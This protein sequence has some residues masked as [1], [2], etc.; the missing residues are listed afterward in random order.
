[1][2]LAALALYLSTSADAQRTKPVPRIDR[3]T[4][5]TT[6]DPRVDKTGPMEG[7]VIKAIVTELVDTSWTK[8]EKLRALYMWETKH[9]AFDC[10]AYHHPGNYAANASV[11]LNERKTTS[12]GFALFFKAMCDITGIECYVVEGLLRT[13]PG[14]IGKL[15]NKHRHYWNVAVID[16]VQYLVDPT[17]GAGTTDA[18]K[19]KFT[20]NRTDVWWL[21]NRELFALSHYP[22][23]PQWQLLEKPVTRSEFSKA[24]VITAHTLALGLLPGHAASGMLRGR[25]D[26]VVHLHYQVQRPHLVRNVKISIEEG[27]PVPVEYALDGNNMTVKVPYTKAGNKQ[28]YS[29]YVNDNKVLTYMAQ[30]RPYKRP[31]PKVVPVTKP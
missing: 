16:D 3:E 20:P 10:R 9:I 8:L 18:N 29:L 7:H 6:I 12:K 11:A 23:K 26:T 22:D 5:I 25:E 31:K 17:L 28:D 27:N 15:D 13:E 4:Y 2:M 14:E 19:R 21:A 24:P 30:V 1:M